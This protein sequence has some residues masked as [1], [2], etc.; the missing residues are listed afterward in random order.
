VRPKADWTRVN[1]EEC[2]GAVGTASKRARFTRCDSVALVGVI[3]LVL[4]A[5]DVTT[6]RLKDCSQHTHC[7]S[8]QFGSAATNAP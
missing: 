7:S 6:R 8:V 2:S 4:P 1:N 5:A 3:T